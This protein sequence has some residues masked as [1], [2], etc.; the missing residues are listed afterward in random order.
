MQEQD[1]EL[2]VRKQ[3]RRCVA[4]ADRMRPVVHGALSYLGHRPAAKAEL[5]RIAE[6]VRKARKRA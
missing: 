4:E 6:L 3:N 2:K 1:L 5:R